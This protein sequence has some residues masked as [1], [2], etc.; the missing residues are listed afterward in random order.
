MDRE[1][2]PAGVME[3]QR[4]GHNLAIEQ[5]QFGGF[6]RQAHAKMKL[7]VQ[8][9][10]GNTCEGSQEKGVRV[11]E[12]S[13]DPDTGLTMLQEERKKGEQG[14]ETYI[15]SAALRKSQPG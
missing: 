5:Q 2:W 14:R 3:S 8:E 13:P 9:V 7:E 11:D 15:Y 4:V 1:A 6:S 12:G 10:G